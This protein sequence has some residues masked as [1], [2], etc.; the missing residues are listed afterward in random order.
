MRG[1][2]AQKRGRTAA[3]GPV[4]SLA[5]CHH[6]RGTTADAADAWVGN[7]G[8]SST[9]ASTVAIAAAAG[10]SSSSAKTGGSD[11]SNRHKLLAVARGITRRAVPLR[12]ARAAVAVVV[13]DR[14]DPVLGN[15]RGGTA[16]RRRLPR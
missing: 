13:I 6:P 2:R 15:A 1:E 16:R 4:G 5:L 11:G 3:A 7:V 10:G 9:S 14:R 8:G 12:P